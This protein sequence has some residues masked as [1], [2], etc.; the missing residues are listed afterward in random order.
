MP[1]VDALA[2]SRCP[3]YW[4]PRAVVEGL[5]PAVTAA[6]QVVRQLWSRMAC[7]ALREPDATGWTGAEYWC[8][9]SPRQ[10]RRLA[11][12][13]CAA[14]RPL[15]APPPPL[16]S[17]QI[18]ERGRGLTFHFD[19]DEHVMKASGAM[20]NPLRSSVLYLTGSS[21]GGAGS[22]RGTETSIDSSVATLRQAPTVLIDQRYDHE[23]QCALPDEPAWTSLV[24]PGGVGCP[25]L[26]VCCYYS[27]CSGCR[28]RALP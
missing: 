13:T 21:G 15:R 28:L 27:P 2:L 7:D 12:S 6:E 4:V 24:F 1:Q 20:V 9:A 14:A 3:N 22:N 26:S 10:H 11:T 8:Q 25:A 5:Q 23:R 19:K 17:L 16:P 18:Y